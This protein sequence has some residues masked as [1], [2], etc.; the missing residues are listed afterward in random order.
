MLLS[1]SG[2]GALVATLLAAGHGEG[3]LVAP[4]PAEQHIYGGEVTEPCGWPST[5]ALGQLCTGTLIHPS[6]VV[7]AAHCGEDF[8]KVEFG[9]QLH[10]QQARSVA[11][12]YCEAWP[13]KLIP[14]DGTDWAYCVLEEPQNDIPIVPPLMGCEVDRLTPGQ[15]VTLVGFGRSE[16]GSGVKRAVTAPFVRFEV[17]EAGAPTE[18]FVGGDGKDACTGDSGGPAFVQ[19]DDGTWRT[20]GIT[21]YG[22][23]NC[24]GGGYSSLL[25]RGM[26]W[27]EAHSGFD[28]TPCHDALGHW[29]GGPACDTFPSDPAAGG[30]E[31][32][33]G[34]SPAER[35]P[36]R[37]D[38]GEPF[39][40]S[41]DTEPPL[42]AIASPGNGEVFYLAAGRD[43]AIIPVEIV[44]TDPD[45]SGI[46]EVVLNEM[47]DQIPSFFLPPY[48]TDI[49]L[50]QGEHVLTATARDAVGNETVSAVVT[51]TVRISPEEG[52]TPSGEGAQQCGCRSDSPTGAAGWLLLCLVALCRRR[53][54]SERG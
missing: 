3:P 41:A 36:A 49:E 43:P 46:A 14:G 28:L 33:K 2:A 18:A 4:P 5:V 11:T 54:S 13:E 15:P 40:P 30:G 52:E 24:Q 44:A 53:P 29:L 31:W 7:Y 34:C 27:F 50:G 37:L 8:N 47:S 20:F 1:L 25:S 17:D 48:A 32:G 26:P 51:I 19:L 39:D 22:S 38:C 45:G 35:Q 10:P 42:V 21:S 6:V 9:E 16:V 23:S 12:D